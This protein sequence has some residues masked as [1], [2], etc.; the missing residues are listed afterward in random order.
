MTAALFCCEALALGGSPH[1]AGIGA[2]PA[3]NADVGIDDVLAVA[4]RDGGHGASGSAGAAADASVANHIGHWLHL[5]F[6]L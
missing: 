4:V 5:P 2:A 1:R 6:L 3:V